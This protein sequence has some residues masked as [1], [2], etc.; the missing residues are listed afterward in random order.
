MMKQNLDRADEIKLV[1]VYALLLFAFGKTWQTFWR[2]ELFFATEGQGV[3]LGVCV[4]IGHVLIV[5]I[6]IINVIRHQ[7]LMKEIKAFINDKD[8][9]H[10]AM[11]TSKIK[12]KMT[13]NY[14]VLP[15]ITNVVIT[16]VLGAT[17]WNVML[18]VKGDEVVNLVLMVLCLG[19]IHFVCTQTFTLVLEQK[20]SRAFVIQA[21]TV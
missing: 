17:C 5:M 7:R 16:S 21:K 1:I 10:K 14:F 2:F 6:P 11:M 18:Q 19:A 13:F 8:P 9:F 4:L 15:L 12:D 20:T 3:L